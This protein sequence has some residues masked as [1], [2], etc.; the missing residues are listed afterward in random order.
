[1]RPPRTWS[2]VLTLLGLAIVL[3]DSSRQ[4]APHPF[5]VCGGLPLALVLVVDYVACLLRRPIAPAGP[6]P[7]SR[8]RWLALPCAAL[9]AVSD[10]DRRWAMGARFALSRPAFE[11][12]LAELRSGKPWPGPQWV[13][14]YPVSHI[15][16]HSAPGQVCFV[17]GTS[18]A[19]PVAIGHAPGRT[20]HP[21][22]RRISGDW[23]AIEL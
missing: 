2:V 18:V 9:V 13:G 5:L 15:D 3:E 20:N 4:V 17:V 8:W 22:R 23:F 21:L 1:M 12:A 16:M 19:D 14:L 10:F 11:Q 7:R 6:R